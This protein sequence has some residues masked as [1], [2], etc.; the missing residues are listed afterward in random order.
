MTNILQYADSIKLL[1]A[2]DYYFNDF[3]K[4]HEFYAYA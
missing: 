4:L 2:P 3:E 1:V